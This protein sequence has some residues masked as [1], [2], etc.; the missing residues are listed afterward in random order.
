MTA[1][2]HSALWSVLSTACLQT[3]PWNRMPSSPAAEVNSDSQLTVSLGTLH[4]H[5]ANKLLNYIHTCI[6]AYMH[7]YIHTYIHAYIHTYIHTT[8]LQL[9][10]LHPGQPGW[11]GTR[12]YILPSSEFS[13]AKWRYQRQTHQQSRW[14]ATPSRLIG[15]TICAIP[16]I[17]TPDALPDTTLPIYPVLGQAPDVWNLCNTLFDIQHTDIA[18]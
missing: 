3:R 1:S 15:A 16:T 4:T 5:A 11:A 10:G 6:H 17:F 7:T 9:S 13:G 14:T 2:V 12:R 8:I 18:H